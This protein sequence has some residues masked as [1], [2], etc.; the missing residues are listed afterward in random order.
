MK[1][2]VI[3]EYGGPEVF[4][5][6]EIPEPVLQDHEVLVKVF[7]A[8]VNPV[9]WK[10]RKGN[11]KLF[12]KARFPVVPGYDVSGVIEKCGSAA[13][14]FKAG[15]EVFCRLDHRF[16]G[17]FAEYASTSESTVALKPK[18]I[19]HLHAA[20]IPLA[21]QTALQ[22]LR[23][24]VNIRRGMKV[25]IIGA[26]GGVGHFALQLAKHYGAETTAVCSS[27]HPE[28]LH[29]LQPDHRIDYRETDYLFA[30]ERYDIIFDAAGAHDFLKCRRILTNGGIYITSLPRLKIL[31]HKLV[32]LF[33][34]GKRVRTL[35]QRSRGSDLGILTRLIEEEKL[36][37]IIDSVHTLENISEAHRRAEEYSTEGK[38]IIKIR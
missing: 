15:D 27:N 20:G 6:E 19:D 8:S 12:L 30:A 9:D 5:V 17:A 29:K 36:Q 1:A 2:A 31:I 37:V 16:G 25:M 34:R 3:Y 14:R 35:F 18:N 4:R 11:H 23:D 22:A 33:T 38:I 26:A 28:L 10:Q 7:A 21:G 24:K 13:G 32:S